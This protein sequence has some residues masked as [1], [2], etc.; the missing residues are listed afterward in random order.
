MCK[1]IPHTV[2]A[3]RGSGGL[4]LEAGEVIAGP[5][6]GARPLIVDA[7]Y[8]TWCMSPLRNS[9]ETVACFI[10]IRKNTIENQHFAPQTS[11]GPLR[12][13]MAPRCSQMTPRCF[14]DASR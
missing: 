8:S 5:V 13:Q 4:S 1:V 12:L 2:L 7:I 11:S 9:S 10:Y 14:P 3:L 6:R